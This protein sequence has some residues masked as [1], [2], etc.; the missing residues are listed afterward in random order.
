MTD[1]IH[2]R[3]H[4]TRKEAASPRRAAAALARFDAFIARYNQERRIRPW[5]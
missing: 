4:L 2:E 5:G 3:M 1:L